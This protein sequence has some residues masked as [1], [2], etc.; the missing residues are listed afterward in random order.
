MSKNEKDTENDKKLSKKSKIDSLN[1][2]EDT[3]E[4]IDQVEV[5]EQETT[6]SLKKPQHVVEKIKP[7]DT[8]LPPIQQLKINSTNIKNFLVS[9]NK[10]SLIHI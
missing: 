3:S 6:T 9:E 5:Q 1:K 8:R 7:A 10:L 4:K 2:E